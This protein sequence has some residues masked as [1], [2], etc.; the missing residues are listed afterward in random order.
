MSG[1]P[2][3]HDQIPNTEMNAGIYLRARSYVPFELLKELG[4]IN[5]HEL[6]RMMQHV[7]EIAKN[8]PDS[9]WHHRIRY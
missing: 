6:T 7:E 3:S 5:Q 2:V 4:Q 9:I 1:I 8:Q